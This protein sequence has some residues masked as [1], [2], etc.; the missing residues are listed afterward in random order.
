[1]GIEEL[2]SRADVLFKL[3]EAATQG[4]KLREKAGMPSFVE[5]PRCAG[6]P[7]ALEVLGDDYTGYGDEEQRAK[8][9]AFISQSHTAIDLLRTALAMVEKGEQDY[10]MLADRNNELNRYLVDRDFGTPEN[11][12]QIKQDAARFRWLRDSPDGYDA[13]HA[14]WEGGKELDDFIDA[15]IASQTEVKDD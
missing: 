15:A 5:A 8:D 2:K 11:V 6:M 13:D 12:M 1:M 3:A 10:K 7:Y 4:W 9:A 14:L